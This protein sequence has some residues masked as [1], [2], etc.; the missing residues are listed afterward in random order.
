MVTRLPDWQDRLVAYLADRHA[1]S[2]FGYDH[3]ADPAQDDCCT[4]AGGAVLA[5]TGVDAMAEFRGRYRTAAGAARA[6][7]RYG[8]GTLPATLDTK[9]EPIPPAFAR[10]GDLALVDGA[11]GVVIGADAVLIGREEAGEEARE[12][13][14][15][16]GRDRWSRAWRV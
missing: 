6:L 9:F 14:V 7:R 16:F 10:R 12:G 1:V 11:V 13:L 8:A 4:F 5:L 3:C 2:R 15:R